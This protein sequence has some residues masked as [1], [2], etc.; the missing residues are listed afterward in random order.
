MQ[1]LQSTYKAVDALLKD[2]R[3][4]TELVEAVFASIDKDGSGT[5]EVSEVEEYVFSSCS[6]M[7]IKQT[8]DRSTIR[9]VFEELD[10]DKSSTIDKKELAKFLRS[11]FEEQRNHLA[12]QLTKARKII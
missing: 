10:E 6:E 4:F 9:S 2:E 5:L 3:G 1:E 7:G 8:P 12:K 11:L